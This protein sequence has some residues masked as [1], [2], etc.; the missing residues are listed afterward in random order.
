MNQTQSQAFT[1]SPI[2]ASNIIG[3]DVVNPQK[4]SLGDIKEVMLDPATGKV[5]Y[6][7]V[8]FGGFLGLGEKL[9]A[10]PFTALSYDIDENEYVL[11]VSKEQL[12][13]APGFD[14]DQWPSM[15]DEQWNREV[16]S[17][18]GRQPYWE[19]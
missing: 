16:S 1:H 5:A 4:E 10:V 13:K 2:K 18:Y 19:I 12:K 15:E 3:T 8:S 17:Y 11:D 7:V 9:F 6:A 14:P